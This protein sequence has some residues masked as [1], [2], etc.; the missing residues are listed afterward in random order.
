MVRSFGVFEKFLKKIPIDEYALA[1]YYYQEAIR[2][3]PSDTNTLFKY[4]CFLERYGK[5]DLAEET[6][7]QALEVY[8]YHR[9]IIFILIIF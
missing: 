4:G 2:S 9:Y 1:E 8:P 3:S 6:Y 5:F 7:L